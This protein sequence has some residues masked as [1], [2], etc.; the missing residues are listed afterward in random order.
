MGSADYYADG[1]WNVWCDRCGGKMKAFEAKKTYDGYHVHEKCWYPRHPQEYNKGAKDDQSVPF[2]TASPILNLSGTFAFATLDPNFTQTSG[3]TL[4]NSNLTATAIAGWWPSSRATV[5]MS[6]GTWYWEVVAANANEY[7][8]LTDATWPP[9]SSGLPISSN[10]NSVA[11]AVGSPDWTFNN[12]A[13]YG[14]TTITPQP[15]NVLGFAL[16][17]DFKTLKLYVNGALSSTIS[18]AALGIN[19]PYY[20]ALSIRNDPM[21]ATFNFGA[22]S[23]AYP[24]PAGY[25]MGVFQ[26][27]TNGYVALCNG[28]AFVYVPNIQSTSK[29]GFL[30]NIPDGVIGAVTI[31]ITAGSGF[32]I[33]S[34]SGDDMSQ[35][36]WAVQI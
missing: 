4:S 30:N 15:G 9:S 25:N 12:I 31:A 34:T 28:Q 17:A 2:V 10:T 16:D 27:T 7:I 24:A 14:V 33:T 22:V 20:P 36:A 23:L 5:G 18:L 8:G 1:S 35:Y 11:I 3:I 32:T 13:G 26:M 29:V 21:A 19:A 6:T